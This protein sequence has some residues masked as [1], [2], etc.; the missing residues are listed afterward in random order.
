[1]VPPRAFDNSFDFQEREMFGV[2]L[3]RLVLKFK[4]TWTGSK[5]IF[6]GIAA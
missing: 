1:L 5:Q 2:F 4:V 3:V 6:L